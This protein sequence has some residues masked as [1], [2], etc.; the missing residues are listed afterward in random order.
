MNHLLY[1][2]FTTELQNYFSQPFKYSLLQSGQVSD[3]FT[4][5]VHRVKNMSLLACKLRATR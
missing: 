3:M 4:I 2:R 1:F 5:S